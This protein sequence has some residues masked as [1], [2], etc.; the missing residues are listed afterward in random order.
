MRQT[1]PEE[2]DEKVMD[3]LIEGDHYS[4]LNPNTTINVTEEATGEATAG[5]D[6]AHAMMFIRG[7]GSL[8]GFHIQAIL[9]Y[10]KKGTI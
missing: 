3:G 7:G 9:L 1:V 6:A 8:M 5:E 4:V 2:L 10:V